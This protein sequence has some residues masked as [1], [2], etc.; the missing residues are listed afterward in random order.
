MDPSY[1]VRYAELYRRHWWWRAREDAVLH[2]IRRLRAG[3]RYGRILDVGCGDA[4]FFERL[5]PFGSVVG[6]EPDAN[7]ISDASK[8]RYMIHV[9]QFDDGFVA[10]EPFDIILFLDVLEHLDDPGFALRRARECL[11]PG[12]AIVVTV[13][14]YRWLWTNHDDLNHHRTRYSP[15]DLRALASTCGFDVHELR[16]LFQLL[17][18]PKLTVH[19]WERLA[20]RPPRP[21][22][23]PPKWMNTLLLSAC[24]AERWVSQ[25]IKVPMGSSLI[26]TLSAGGSLVE[27]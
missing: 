19:L 24:R 22:T 11:A 25:W 17:V 3:R 20:T 1:G 18:V 5:Q 27:S 7:L 21:P 9:G 15:A 13:P 12:G 16:H 6:V 23:V 8:K 4:L 14:A 10:V 26:A 2:V